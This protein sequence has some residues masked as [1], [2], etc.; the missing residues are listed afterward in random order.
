MSIIFKEIERFIDQKEYY[1]GEIYD[2]YERFEL[3]S[4]DNLELR[5]KIIKIGFFEIANQDI[6]IINVQKLWENKK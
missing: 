6:N 1:N 5:D 3:L 4:R 2:E